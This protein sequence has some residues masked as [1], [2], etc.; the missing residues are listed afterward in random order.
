MVC[1]IMSQHNVENISMNN[2]RKDACF[3]ENRPCL[4][5]RFSHIIT[6]SCFLI[7]NVLTYPAHAEIMGYEVILNATS[8]DYKPFH[9]GHTFNSFSTQRYFSTFPAVGDSFRA[10]FSVDTEIPS[11]T[12]V[13]VLEDGSVLVKRRPVIFKAEVGGLAWDIN[14]CG[15]SRAGFAPISIVQQLP[16]FTIAD[17]QVTGMDGILRRGSAIWVLFNSHNNSFI[18]RAANGT[19]SGNYLIR[20]ADIAGPSTINHIRG[21][22]WLDN[23][24]NGYQEYDEPGFAKTITGLGAPVMAL[25]PQGGSEFI[26]SSRLDENSAGQ[27]LFDNVPPGNYY[28]CMSR[29]YDVLGLSVTTQDVGNDSTDSDFDDSP[30]AY[31][32]IVTNTQGV[33]VDLGLV[34]GSP[35]GQVSGFVWLDNNAN[36]LQDTGE[37]GFARTVTGLGAPVMKL[38]PQGST[39]F[40]ATSRLDE[41]SAGVFLFKNVLPGNYYVCMSREYDVLGLSVTTQDAGD[42][43]ID[44]DFDDAPCAYD[45]SVTNNQSTDIDL[46]LVGGPLESTEP[47]DPHAGN[48]N[49]ISI[50]T[51]T[52]SITHQWQSVGNQF[53]TDNRVLF[54]SAPTNHGTQRGVARMRRTDTSAE[55]KFQEWSNLDGVH[56][57]E[58]IHIASFPQGSWNADNTQIE[59]GTATV[60][61]TRQWTTIDFDTAFTRKPAVITTLQTANGRDAVDVHVRNITTTSMQVALFEEQAKMGTW[62]QPETVG[63][64]LVISN[65]DDSFDLGNSESTQIALPCNNTGI[66]INHGWQSICGIGDGFQVRLEEDQTSDKET[67]HV[68]E[69]VQVIKVDDVPLTQIASDNGGDP[70]VLRSRKK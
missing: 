65:T 5:R 50:N 49:T 40:I 39:E 44:N 63:Y 28:V 11:G 20:P 48:L 43:L 29:E 7:C 54:F 34:G 22:V 16:S 60:S 66:A 32:I 12:D 38:Y 33:V 14:C 24:A 3:S 55:F 61:G 59:V 68:F 64:L 23:N 51:E 4:A 42:D 25:Y 19:I 30:C 67:F 1:G 62:H 26:A 46:G 70:A 37:P 47:V 6:L 9:P 57:N 45:I 8:T 18:V 35:I 58:T 52:L 31:D 13:T 21:S 17:N 10:V 41:N 69:T 15:N 36:G 53:N 27:F 2:Y 56:N